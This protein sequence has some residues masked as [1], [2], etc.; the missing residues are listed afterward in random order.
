VRAQLGK[1]AK[2]RSDGTE[3]LAATG[4]DTALKADLQM[5]LLKLESDYPAYA[6]YL[7][8]NPGQ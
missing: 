5:K 6:A 1:F 3:A 4:Q 8:A 7:K 2:A